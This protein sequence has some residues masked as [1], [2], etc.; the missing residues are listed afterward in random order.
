[1]YLARRIT[2]GRFCAL[3]VIEKSAIYNDNR[4]EMVRTEDKILRLVDHPFVV[5]MFASFE[6][7]KY[8]VFVLDRKI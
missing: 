7:S 5:K 2:D 8:V 1:M 4:L 6:T 3:K